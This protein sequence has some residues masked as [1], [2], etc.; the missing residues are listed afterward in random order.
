MKRN[1]LS[2]IITLALSLLAFASCENNNEL[3]L[4]GT[5]PCDN[6]ALTWDTGISEIFSAYCVY[7]H[8]KVVHYKDVRH[9]IYQEELKV[10]ADD[11]GD[12]LRAVINHEGGYKQMPFELPKLSDCNIEKIETWLDNGALEN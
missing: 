11:G 10:I 8:N 3:D 6:T 2:L 4:Y 1:N 7:C 9:D 12:R 5:E